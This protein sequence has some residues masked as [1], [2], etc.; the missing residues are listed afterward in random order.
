M[1]YD[2]SLCEVH[3]DMLSACRKFSLWSGINQNEGS[4][5]YDGQLFCCSDDY[6]DDERGVD[7]IDDSHRS[8]WLT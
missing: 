4:A 2:G 8:H 1:V 7:K 6:H 5:D 3:D